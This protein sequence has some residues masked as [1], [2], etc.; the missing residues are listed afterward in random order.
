MCAKSRMYVYKNLF[1][2]RALIFAHNVNLHIPHAILSHTVFSSF[3]HFTVVGFYWKEKV[4]DEKTPDWFIR[5]SKVRDRYLNSIMRL[6]ANQHRD[7][8]FRLNTCP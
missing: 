1:Y 8:S 4:M 5:I 3:R 7:S 2:T 6:D